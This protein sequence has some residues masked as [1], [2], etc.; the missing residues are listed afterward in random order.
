MISFG[1]ISLQIEALKAFVKCETLDGN[2]QYFCE[3]CNKKCDAQKGLKF[4]H[5][6]YLL[7]L[8]LKRFDYDYNTGH[9]IK[10][11]DRWVSFI[12]YFQWQI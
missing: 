5:F 10:L 12:T 2:N 7:T 9:R 6:P 4:K 8:H 3:K 1:F 11:N